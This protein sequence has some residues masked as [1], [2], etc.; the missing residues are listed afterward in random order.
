MT[1]AAPQPRGRGPAQGERSPWAALLLL[2]PALAGLA[3]GLVLLAA[4]GGRRLVFTLSIAAVPA[5]LGLLISAVVALVVA[6]RARE[7]RRRERTRAQAEEAARAAHRRFL[8][9]LDHELKNPVTAVRASAAAL[10]N[11]AD[12]ADRERLIGTVDAQAARLSTLVADL[13]KLAEIESGP[14]EVEDV[15]VAQ[16]IDEAVTDMRD[17]APASGFGSRT[18]DVVLPRAPWPLPHVRGD[19]DLIYLAVYNLLSNAV[20][21]AASEH[22]IEVR[23]SDDGAHVVIEVADRGIGIPEHEVAGVFDELA[24]GSQARGIPGSGLGLSLVRVIAERHGG[25]VAIRS[26]EGAGTS[27]RVRLPMAGPPA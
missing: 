21:F 6:L 18:I 19:V 4:V 1:S 25:D 2:A 16:V 23:G 14:I 9:R 5:L 17:Q 13:R 22:P 26:R 8:A 15:D 27:V 7:R 24:R 10:S 11:A 12:P 20:K 3:V